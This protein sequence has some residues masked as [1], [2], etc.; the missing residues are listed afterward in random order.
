[1]GAFYRRLRA[2]RPRDEALREAQLDLIRSGRAPTGGADLSH[3]F[4]WA[5][6][7]LSGDWR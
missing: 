6:F 7:Q 5:A 4:H 3:P 2:G 1:M